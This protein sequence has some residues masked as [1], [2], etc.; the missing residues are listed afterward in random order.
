VSWLRLYTDI[1][2][3]ANI[4]TLE[5]RFFR[6]WVLSMLSV[7]RNHRNPGF[8]PEFKQW[9]LDV[10][11]RPDLAKQH[12]DVLVESGL[13]DR[14][15]SGLRHHNWDNWQYKSDDVNARV[16]DWRKRKRNVTCNVTRNVAVTHQNTEYRVQKQNTENPAPKSPSVPSNPISDGFDFSP[17]FEALYTLGP[18]KAHK[19]QARQMLASDS[20]MEDS[21]FR[22]TFETR[23][24]EWAS[25]MAVDYHPKRTLLEWFNDEGWK[26]E[27]PKTV[28]KM[29]YQLD[30][31]EN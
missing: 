25:Y 12:L 6:T 30:H 21:G 20:R 17:W 11:L 31:M 15:D 10:K 18:K 23:W 14:T 19:N 8:L 22:E 28:S 13:I 27:I 3:D 29:D 7:K 9:A 16:R 4:I 26:D 1:L 24:R 2:D 5:S